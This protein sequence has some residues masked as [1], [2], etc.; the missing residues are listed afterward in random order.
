MSEPKKP[1]PK[2]IIDVAHP[3]KSSPALTSKP[4]LVTN[5]PILKDPMV[6]DESE[7][8]DAAAGALQKV[9]VKTAASGTTIKPIG[10]PPLEKA[11]KT[12]PANDDLSDEIK[13][14]KEPTPDL[15]STDEDALEPSSDATAQTDDADSA[16]SKDEKATQSKPLKKDADGK[17]PAAAEATNTEKSPSATQKNAA[18]Q[19]QKKLE[20]EDAAQSAHAI[21]IQ[22]LV[23]SK[24][25]FLPIN[26]VEKRRSKRFVS[27]GILLSIILALAW[28]DIALDAGLIHVSSVKPLTHFFSN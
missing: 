19:I 17:K 14:S 5:R 1:A 15:A 16:G 3:G 23:D 27:L 18:G 13:R 24:Q 25:Y 21:T 11:D 26:A 28:A 6:V 12:P 2:R 20:A 7:P 10:P 22:K 8:G 4:V 9:T